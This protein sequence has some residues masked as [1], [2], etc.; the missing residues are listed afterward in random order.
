VAAIITSGTVK[1]SLIPLRVRNTND[2]RSLVVISPLVLLGRC[3]L[4]ESNGCK[5]S[6]RTAQ[7]VVQRPVYKLT[8]KTKL[9]KRPT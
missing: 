1:N 8:M 9:K 7:K 2:E 3:P 6:C 4:Q 5:P